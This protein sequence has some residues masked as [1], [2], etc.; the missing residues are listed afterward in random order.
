VHAK[1]FALVLVCAALAL[2]VTGHSAERGIAEVYCT[3]TG[4]KLVYDCMIMLVGKQS[5]KPI[6][7]AKVV[8]GAAM[9]SM[10]MAHNVK[11]VKAM[12]KG[13]PGMYH[14]RLHLAM[15]GEWA[16]TMDVS[17]PTRDK[18]IHTMRFGSHE[19]MKH[20]QGEMTHE[21]M[22]KPESMKQE[23]MTHEGMKHEGMQHDK[24]KEE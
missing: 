2:P 4:E 23:D 9:P 8:V 15:E 5:G 1:I 18:L 13:K 14:A 21:G 7:G 3:P 10:P 6:E 24:G 22:K 17:G 19:G 16:L 12:A 20:E 11:P